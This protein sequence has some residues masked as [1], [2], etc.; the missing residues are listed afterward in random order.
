MKKRKGFTLVEL[1]IVIIII[2]IL[3]GSLL[4]TAGTASNKTKALTIINN[5]NSM[6]KAALIHYS[7]TGSW[8]SGVYS[9]GNWGYFTVDH[10]NEYLDRGIP[11]EYRIFAEENSSFYGDSDFVYLTCDLSGENNGVLKALEKLAEEHSLYADPDDNGNKIEIY[12]S[13]FDHNNEVVMVL[14]R[15]TV[16]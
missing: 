13:K 5:M 14:N 6:K 4:L 11:G 9:N 15:R 8:Y 7:D 3:S 2:G 10:L 12:S 16:N 1:L